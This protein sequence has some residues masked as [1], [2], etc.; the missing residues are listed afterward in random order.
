VVLGVSLLMRSAVV[1]REVSALDP[2]AGAVSG[3]FGPIELQ[4]TR[5]SIA[6]TT[7]H[8]IDKRMIGTSIA[9]AFRA[10]FVMALPV[11][12]RQAPAAP[13]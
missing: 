2:V 3:T 9:T 8:G 4:A 12:K 13:L 6:G 10:I 11:G 7:T 5:A 1:R